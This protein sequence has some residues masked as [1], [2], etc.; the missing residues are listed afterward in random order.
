MLAK[1]PP[2]TPTVKSDYTQILYDETFQFQ[3]YEL[4]SYSYER[5][6]IFVGK[7]SEHTFFHDRSY[8]INLGC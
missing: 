2:D 5:V 3:S 1:L 4:A 8:L 7:Y 6:S